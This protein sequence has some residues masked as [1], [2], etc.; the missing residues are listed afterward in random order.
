MS[1]GSRAERPLAARPKASRSLR[2]SGPVCV[3]GYPFFTLPIRATSVK[4]GADAREVMPYTYLKTMQSLSR[5]RHDCCCNGCCHAYVTQVHKAG[6]AADQ[7]ADT[8]EVHV[9]TLF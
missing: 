7:Q 2:E 3:R 9:S 4:P 6:G 1:K 5:L 8:H